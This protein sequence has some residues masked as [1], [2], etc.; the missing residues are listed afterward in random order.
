MV[1][2]LRRTWP[3]WWFGLILGVT[4]LAS[5]VIDIATEPNF[6]RIAF[7]VTL[8]LFVVDGLGYLLRYPPSRPPDQT[9]NGNP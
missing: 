7:G 1:T 9:D 4:L 8:A 2:W 6:W 3:R 5:S